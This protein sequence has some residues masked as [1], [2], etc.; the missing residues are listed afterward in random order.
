[1]EIVLRLELREVQAF[2]RLTVDRDGLGF[3]ADEEHSWRSFVSLA[4]GNTASK[5]RTTPRSALVE[6]LVVRSS[7]NHHF[8]STNNAHRVVSELHRDLSD[9]DDAVVCGFE[10]SSAGAS[11]GRA[12]GRTDRIGKVHWRL[13]L[14]REVD[15]LEYRSPARPTSSASRS[16][17]F[18]TCN[19]PRLHN[20]RRNKARTIHVPVHLCGRLLREPGDA[21]AN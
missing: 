19:S 15:V 11:R 5:E 21:A 17:P 20:T 16:P 10:G 9:E 18:R 8:S 7:L 6:P 2:E 14:G 4:L 13:C 3:E 12:Q 1:M